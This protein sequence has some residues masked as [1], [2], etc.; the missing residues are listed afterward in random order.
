MHTMLTASSSPHIRSSV[1]TQR[2]MWTV[3][4]TLTP[5]M[6]FGV[7]NFGIRSFFL[8]ITSIATAVICEY[9]YE[10]LLKKKITINDGSAVLTGL[11]LAM[12]LPPTLPFYM[13]AIGAA[14]AIIVAKHSM[15]GLGY[16]VFNPAL[17]ARAALT[18]SWPVAMTT[19]SGMSYLDATT[20]ATPLH[21]VSFEGYESLL[22]MF[23]T[24][25]ALYW[26][27]FLGTKN[28]SLGETS[29]L[30][31]LLGGLFLLYKGYVKWQ[32]PVFMILTVAVSSWIFNGETL[33]TG[34]PILGI[35][36]GGVMLGAFFM[37]TDYATTPITPKGRIIFAIGVG[38]LTVLI[39]TKGAYPEG[40]CYAILL[41]NSLTPLIDKITKP[42]VFGSSRG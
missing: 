28:G 18:L 38:L 34:D 7:Y 41:M 33:F 11:L 21:I 30:F 4:A 3:V 25:L 2:I 24:K 13:V 15:G 35:L 22:H 31:I 42:K 37:A 26:E 29:G 17:A 5:V 32:V 14:F 40:V 1:T 27:M 9:A 6:I 16:N 19:W 36:T 8:M 10:K 39:R 20:T 23:S 12:T